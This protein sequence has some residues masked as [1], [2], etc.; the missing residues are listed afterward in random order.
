[1]IPMA[2]NVAVA[3]RPSRRIRRRTNMS[4]KSSVR[5]RMRKRA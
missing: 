2:V 4:G 5:K 3:A 1:M